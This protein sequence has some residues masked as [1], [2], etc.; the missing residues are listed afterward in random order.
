VLLL[1]PHRLL[2]C[3][4]ELRRGGLQLVALL[5]P[6]LR[7]RLAALGELGLEILRLRPKQARVQRRAG[8]RS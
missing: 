4:E 7:R 8:R 1:D 6:R 3:L 2:S 5:Q